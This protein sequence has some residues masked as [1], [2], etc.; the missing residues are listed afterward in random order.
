MR[1]TFNE[2][3]LC[4]AI[5]LA[6]RGYTNIKVLDKQAYHETLYSYDKGCDTASADNTKIIRAAYGSQIE[7]G[8]IV[9]PGFTLEDVLFV[10]NGN[11]TLTSSE[12]LPEFEKRTIKNMTEVG[13]ADTQIV[14]TN[15]SDV[16][17]ATANGFG[18]AINPLNRK[19]SFGLLDIQ[20]GFVYADN[21]C[22]FALQKAQS[23]GAR[24]VLGGSEG[25]LSKLLYDATSRVIGVQTADGES[26]LAE[27][28]IMACGGW[29]PS[30]VPKLDGLC[31][32]TA[33]SVCMFQLPRNSSQWDRFAPERF[34]TWTYDIRSGKNGALYGFARDANGILKIGYRGA[35]FTNPQTQSD[36]AARSVP[37]T[38]WTPQSTRQLPLSAARVIQ[39]FVQENLPELITCPTK[40]R[41]C[42]YTDSF[43]NHF[44]ID[45][46]PDSPGL[47]VATGGSGHGF[48][49]LPNLGSHVVD[50]IEGKSNVAPYNKIME[51]VT[52][53][54]TL[55][56]QPLTDE[57]KLTGTACHL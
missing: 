29:T 41:L 11:L 56:N 36:G 26:H 43:D 34:P 20:G 33:G 47:M 6:Q 46:V 7:S 2:Q 10:N 9:P 23:I 21:A 5:H 14:L 19:Q 35:K 27:L 51:G 48:K 50:R 31:E 13:L 15:S 45:F 54:R 38:R 42:W 40:S 4:T 37:I 53:Q 55:Q 44:V 57:D 25:T 39:K 24:F 30:L 17:R 3:Q 49:F 18:F 32:T 28:T 12:T 22:R 52:S 16:K 8:K 1:L